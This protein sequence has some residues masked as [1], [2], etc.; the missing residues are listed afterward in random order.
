MNKK[1]TFG[2]SLLTAAILF[3][4]TGAGPTPTPTKYDVSIAAGGYKLCVGQSVQIGVTYSLHEGQK[5]TAAPSI[6]VFASH[7]TVTPDTST[8]A[9]GTGY[10]GFRYTAENPGLDN[11]EA[12][13]NGGTDGS[14]RTTITVLRECQYSYKLII[15][16]KTTST[17]GDLLYIW[18]DYYKSEDTFAVAG[19][20]GL[21]GEQII[22]SL[23]AWFSTITIEELQWPSLKDCNVAAT[24]WTGLEGTGTLIVR[25]EMLKASQQDMVRI[26][27]L[28]AA[29]DQTV[30]FTTPCKDETRTVTLP[31]SFSKEPFLQEDFPLS[32]GARN[33][34]IAFFENGVNR[35][36]SG[37][38]IASYQAYLKIWRVK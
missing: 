22:Q 35:L 20:G 8:G 32:G 38:T 28:S 36:Q 10:V 26:N 18:Q 34:H 37:F 12:F 6:Y 1:L 13:I 3:L 15:L 24:T 7:G 5:D 14:A 16:L 19:P 31:L 21:S 27:F 17:D 9:R 23:K 29:M 11:I 25:G 2:M 4:S 33:I 30:T